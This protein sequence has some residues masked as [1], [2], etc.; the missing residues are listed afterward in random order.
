MYEKKL[1]KVI[2]K[3]LFLNKLRFL[4]AF[5]KRRMFENA[6]LIKKV[7]KKNK[8]LEFAGAKQCYLT[9]AKKS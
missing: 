8:T 3:L 1:Q 2:C 6:Y 4:K 5:I 7:Y 9:E